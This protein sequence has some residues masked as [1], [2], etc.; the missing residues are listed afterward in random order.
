MMS[1]ASSSSSASAPAIRRFQPRG[2]KLW[3]R[4]ERHRA[5]DGTFQRNENRATCRPRTCAKVH[6]QHGLCHDLQGKRCRFLGD[7]DGLDPG[8]DDFPSIQH[9]FG[10]FDDDR[11]QARHSTATEG[12]LH[13]LPP[14]RPGTTFAR[15]DPASEYRPLFSVG[16]RE[17]VIAVIDL[18]DVAHMV[19]VVQ[20]VYPPRACRYSHDV[21][22]IPGK[23][24]E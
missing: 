16:R 4:R 9:L 6:A 11:Y 3:S 14:P 15:E 10:G 8:R 18:Q 2:P 17:P 20:E 7:I 12:W 13:E 1:C 19:R 23:L 24:T 21:A 5:H 22:V